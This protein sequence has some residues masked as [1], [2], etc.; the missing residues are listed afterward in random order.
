MERTDVN[1]LLDF[2]G[3]FAIKVYE[4]RN[5]FIA[6]HSYNLQRNFCKLNLQFCFKII[7]KCNGGCRN[8]GRCIAPNTCDCQIGYSG[9]NCKKGKSIYVNAIN[10]TQ[11]NYV[12]L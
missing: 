1:V 8:G 12:M 6:I 11:S 7:A 10:F 9:R 3:D 5:I 2:V 4:H